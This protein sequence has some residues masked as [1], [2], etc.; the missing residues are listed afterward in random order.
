MLPHDFPHWPAVYYYFKKWKENGLFEEVLDNLNECE[1]K[2]HKKK[3]SPSVGIIDSQ[4]V[5]TAHT[6]AQDIGY[7]AGKRMKGRK[8]HIVTDTLSC[9]LLL[10]VHGVNVQDRKG[11]RMVLPLFVE[12]QVF[13]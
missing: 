1:C 12:I 2:L 7:D 9:L 13:G 3:S 8:R 11:I 10:P 4:S 6:C 5:K